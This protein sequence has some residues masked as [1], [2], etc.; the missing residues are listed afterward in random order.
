MAFLNFYSD[1]Y[2]PKPLPKYDLGTINFINTS[3]LMT[4]CWIVDSVASKHI[5]KN[6]SFF[7]YIV[8][9]EPISIGL[10]NGTNLS[11]SMK[12]D[13]CVTPHITLHGVYYVSSFNINLPSVS[14]LTN[15]SNYVVNFI[16]S[17]VVV[18]DNVM[19]KTTG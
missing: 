6:T 5:S 2:N 19:K 10:P 17:H 9:C 8:E 18:F 15:F 16:K 14:K 4:D 1:K 13:V 11:V 7:S 3:H 12:G